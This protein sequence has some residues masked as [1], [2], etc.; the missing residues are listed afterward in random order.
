MKSK[1]WLLTLGSF[2]IILIGG[3]FFAYP[4]LKKEKVLKI[5]QPADINPK[6]VD[7]S[8][9]G[10]KKDHTIADFSLV[11]QRGENFTQS[12]FDDK[13]Y[14]ANFFFATCPTI[15]PIMSSHFSDLQN[16][17][18]DDSK[19]MFI[20]YSVTPDIDSV[21]VLAEYGERYGTN[22][23][24]W[25]LAT[26]DKKEIYNIARKSYFAVLDE[27]DGGVQDFIHTEN[28]ILV[29]SKSRIRGYYDGT[30]TA[31]MERLEDEIRILLKEENSAKD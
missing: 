13:I 11:N 6:L 7:T 12:V 8:K 21:A 19:V 27:G 4:L 10:V 30:S 1:T 2:L 5:Y 24:K 15:C 3:M 9:Q 20:S 22:P 28:M 31:D 25:I 26:G 14:V 23:D 29:D 17:F 18:M 16:T